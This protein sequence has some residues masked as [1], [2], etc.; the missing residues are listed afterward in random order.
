MIARA[1]YRLGQSE[2]LGR[3][4]Y[5]ILPDIPERWKELHQRCLA[6]EVL[7]SEEDL[8]ERA[9]G[10]RLWRRW[11]LRPWGDRGGLPEGLFIFT[12]DI[13]ERKNAEE[14][15]RDQ[16]DRLEKIIAT[17]PGA[18]CSFRLHP[19]GETSFPYMSPGFHGM[20]PGLPDLTYD[21]A[22]F[23][24]AMHP[25]DVERV[26]SGIEKS[27]RDMTPWRYDYRICL[28]SKGTIWVDGN[29]VPKSEPDGSVLW[30]GF[31]SDITERKRV[32]QSLLQSKEEYR[33]LV[34]NSPDAIARFDREGRFLLVNSRF[35]EITGRS[36][37]TVI[38]RGPDE[39]G[40][41]ADVVEMGMQAVNHVFTTGTAATFEV[42]YPSPDGDTI[43]QAR[44][45]PE[46]SLSGALQSAIL[47][48]LDITERKRSEQ[49]LLQ[50]KAAYRALAD[51]S[52]DTITRL[53]SDCR[54]T[55]VNARTQQLAGLPEE[56]FIGKRVDAI[57]LTPGQADRWMAQIR[58][59]F[60]TGQPE[61]SEV[62]YKAAGGD[63]H[64]NIR[65]IPEF[66]EDGSVQSVLR[67]GLD[68]TERRRAE[69][70]AHK[71]AQAA[72]EREAII[73]TLFDTAG[74]GIIGVGAAGNIQLANRMA[75]ELFGYKRDELL[76][77]C[78]EELLPVPL[79]HKHVGLRESFMSM[80]RTRS[81]LRELDLLGRHKDG[82]I[83]PIEVNLS[84]VSGSDG[85]LAVAF[86]SDITERKQNELALRKSE[87]EM[88]EL[89][90]A[91]IAAEDETGRRIAR[92]LHDDICQRLAAL[93]MEFR[94]SSVSTAAPE[95][96][97]QQLQAFQAKIQG[98][99][100]SVR[101]IS[102]QMHPSI[103]DDL[104]IEA[105]LQSMCAEVQQIE[106]TPIHFA[107]IN[108]DD[109][110]EYRVAFCLYR[111]CQE[112]LRNVAKH[113]QA[114]EVSVVLSRQDDSIQ[115]AVM[116]SG[117]GFDP[118][119]QE[120]GLGTKSMKERVRLVGGSLSI[121]SQPGE[122]TSVIVRIPLAR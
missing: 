28:P 109:D 95:E 99:S 48:A 89:N 119:R 20:F 39:A 13:T 114:Q 79:R 4:H 9:D 87:E 81:M 52:P 46:F 73:T 75:E 68:I 12:E 59:V 54:Y 69:A 96:F 53:D 18:I 98:I 31:L 88:R 93:S 100:E 43:W 45:I 80:P 36:E 57:V 56:A 83:F 5:E 22:A 7:R 77:L 63:T 33:A 21:A 40:F 108:V 41:P 10:S 101:Q 35:L 118:A 103:L 6:G 105:A 82:S 92:E 122:G 24:A 115:L 32:E 112:S 61:Q 34:D 8:F 70:L 120:V 76:G 60:S 110:I 121:E 11:E 1:D 65:L 25:D 67:I 64:W 78:L 106:Q 58:R 51:N 38:G 23:F 111:V 66:R 107:A 117:I 15:L 49:A 37:E 72:S 50:A 84:H 102:R 90:D 62:T 29:S 14:Q 85:V 91:L 55:F 27:A 94:R 97:I 17:A 47:I 116:D 113:A 44:I 3:S 26:R 30:Y 16:H 74:Q 104:G 42:T 86:I 71:N 2:L 19:N